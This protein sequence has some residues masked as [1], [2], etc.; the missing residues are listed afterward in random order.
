MHHH[1]DSGRIALFFETRKWEGKI[2]NAEPDKCAGWNWFPLTDLPSPL[3]PYTADALAFY[4]K[5]EP[6]AERGWKEPAD[7]YFL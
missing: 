5:D 3:I 1:S 4:R 6:Y 2:I 7:Q